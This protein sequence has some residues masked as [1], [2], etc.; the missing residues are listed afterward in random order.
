MALTELTRSQTYAC[1]R[2]YYRDEEGRLVERL[3]H[4]DHDAIVT[5]NREKASEYR[6]HA[7]SD[8]R[9]VAEVPVDIYLKWLYEE[10]LPVFADE[11]T[12]EMVWRK[13]LSDPDYKYLLTV[14]SSY[15][16]MRHG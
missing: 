12:L 10:D 3:L 9:V 2:I 14:P 5:A 7:K 6:P 8:I 15:R 11:T 1:Q 4:P 16:M 13:K